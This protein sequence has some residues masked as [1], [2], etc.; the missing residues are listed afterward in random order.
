MDV[1]VETVVMVPESTITC[2]ITAVPAA[3]FTL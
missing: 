3:I 1:T 2:P